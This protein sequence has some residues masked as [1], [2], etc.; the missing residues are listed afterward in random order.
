MLSLRDTTSRGL[1][2][3][4]K[5]KRTPEFVTPHGHRRAPDQ[6][7]PS[8][9]AQPCL[10]ARR[11]FGVHGTFCLQRYPV[12]QLCFVVR[13]GVRGRRVPP[14]NMLSSGTLYRRWRIS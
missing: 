2:S 3:R 7:R 1:S 6:Q 12:V 11:G 9:V 10:A 13:C 5:K 14:H 4:A 8:H